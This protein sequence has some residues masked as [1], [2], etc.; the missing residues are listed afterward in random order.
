MTISRTTCSLW[1]SAAIEIWNIIRSDL[2]SK[3]IIRTV[4]SMLKRSKEATKKERTERKTTKTSKQTKNQTRKPKKS[5]IKLFV[6]ID[7]NFFRTRPMFYIRNKTKSLV[8]LLKRDNQRKNM[9]H[10]SKRVPNI[11]I[12]RITALYALLDSM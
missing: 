7:D 12:S 5:R 6:V 9:L 1:R 10:L 8:K 4:V 2:Y 11:S 3:T